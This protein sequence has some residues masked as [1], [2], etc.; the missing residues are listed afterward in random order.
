MA[1]RTVKSET[2][3]G[4]DLASHSLPHDREKRSYSDFHR[5][6]LERGRERFV[7]DPWKELLRLKPL[8]REG[9]RTAAFHPMELHVDLIK[10][11]V[12]D[13]PQITPTIFKFANMIIKEP[14]N[15]KD[16]AFATALKVAMQ[17]LADEKKALD[18][19]P[20]LSE[21]SLP[22]RE[23]RPVQRTLFD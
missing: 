12:R 20:P 23:K 1:E 16:L 10:E 8:V 17:Q 7:E 18:L 5:S 6:W 22:P 9:N 21:A 3:D 4:V 19:S 15:S 2:G 14:F 13:N 11:W